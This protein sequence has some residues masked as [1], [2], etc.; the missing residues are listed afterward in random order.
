[1]NLLITGAWAEAAARIPELEKMGHRVVF[2]QQ[3]KD[4]LPC[5]PA[6]VEGVVCNGLFLYHPIAAF[7][8]LRLI[9]LTSAGFD[10]VD[11]E[12]IRSRGIALYNARGVYS[13]PMAEFALCGVLEL[14]KQAR[15]FAENQRQRR[16]EKHR[17][18]LELCGRTVTILGCGSVG[19]A[20][21]ER[22][23]A[24]GCRILGVDLY[25]RA[26][27][28]YEKIC[29]LDRLEALLPETD[30]LILTL[31]LTPETRGLMDESRLK[32][33]KPDAVLV[34]I[35]RG[36]ILDERALTAALKAKTLGGA[37]LDVF[38]TE[39]LAEDSP[40]WDLDQVILTP[41]NSFV[42]DR[43]GARL[44]ALILEN[45]RQASER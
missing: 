4:S 30:L 6:W 16:W 31:P 8:N 24:L 20:C 28:A 35:A 32:L 17:G 9:Q 18:V 43:N 15:F 19:T 10:R 33:L 22:F 36:A 21:A 38:D 23:R 7:K 39:P 1:M 14:Y 13:V 41:H 34:N 3:E 5:D 42:S 27:A 26:D 40:L 45:L 11:P 29:S 12:W 37:V 2:L 44:S 25:P